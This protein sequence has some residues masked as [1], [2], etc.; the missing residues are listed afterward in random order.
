METEI[1]LEECILEV[2]FGK[3]RLLYDNV[4]NYTLITL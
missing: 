3:G 1:S 2:D 4:H